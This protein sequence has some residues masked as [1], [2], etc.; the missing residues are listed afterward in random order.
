MA[1]FRLEIVT[2]EGKVFD[3][4]VNMVVAPG[5]EGVMGILP[6]HAP[7]LTR[8]NFGEL[9]IKKD[10]QPDQFYAVGGGVMEVQGTQ[11]IVLAD[12]AEHVDEI[13]ISRAEEARQRAEERLA[14]AS[15]DQ[16]DFDRA[17]AALRRSANRIKLAR[18]HR[19]RG[20]YGVQ[21]P[22]GR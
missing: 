18:R 13:D 22:D 7:L 9:H 15:K 8:L 3:E 5:V 2:I 11:V 12:S 4:E 17:E 1:T 10:G 16:L 19:Q 20:G 14:Q 6:H 21:T